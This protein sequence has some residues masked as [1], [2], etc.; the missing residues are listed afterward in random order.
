M[1]ASSTPSARPRPSL[2][3]PQP[4]QPEP[5]RLVLAGALTAAVAGV[6]GLA[7]VT[8]AVVLV[9]ALDD[10]SHAGLLDTVRTGAQLW[11]VA[12]GT[13]LE[14]P[15]GRLG[16]LPLGLAALP[17]VLT[18][19]AGRRVATTAAAAGRGS[20]GRA[21][22]RVA[23]AVAVP[24]A[25]VVTAVAV[26]CADD[27][28]P[29]PWTALVAGLGVAAVG[30]GAAALRVCAQGLLQ[31]V[32]ARV[33][34]VG[35]AAVAAV[36]VL[37][38]AGSLLVAVALGA[39]LGEGA[40]LARASGAG[41]AGGVA[42]LLLGLALAPN[43]ALWGVS[44]LA[45]PGFTVGLETSVG[46]FGVDAGPVPAVPLL[47]ALPAGAPP[48]V[49]ALVVLL[50]PVLAG[51]CAAGVLHRRLRLATDAFSGWQA[52]VHAGSCGAA[53][54]VMVAALAALSGGAVGDERLSVVGP[55]ATQVGAAVAV[56]V[57]LGALAAVLVLR[58]RA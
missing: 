11:L 51:V 41:I 1:T 39:Q 57:A 40:E 20:G 54:G 22:V 37:V 9:E 50:V 26:A 4:A 29:V 7:V 55:A 30:A 48:T 6:V 17:L 21:A 35:A 42:L 43:A 13:H 52:A 8:V 10:R 19:R 44:W 31:R 34:A 36:V 16:L 38:G 14:L 32:P 15:D 56:E 3:R 28:R 24:Y 2:R 58:R 5:R 45:G 47:A 12:H 18:W 33:A 49:V 25:A 46:P 23:G 27:V 53:A